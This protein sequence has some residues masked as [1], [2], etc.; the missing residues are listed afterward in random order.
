MEFAAHYCAGGTVAY[1]NTS[2]FKLDNSREHFCRRSR[3]AVDQD[4]QL[5]L[6]GLLSPA[7]GNDRLGFLSSFKSCYFNVLLEK[8]S[9]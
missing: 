4:N 5:A 7:L 3:I 8:A 6:E 1:H 9:N 2:L